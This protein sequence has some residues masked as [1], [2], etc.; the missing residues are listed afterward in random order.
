MRIVELGAAAIDYGKRSDDLRLERMLRPFESGYTGLLESLLAPVNFTDHG[1]AE[2]MGRGIED[3][4]EGIV[5]AERVAVVFDRLPWD[6]WEL[7]RF[8]DQIALT[9]GLKPA[10]IACLAKLFN[11]TSLWA[12]F[13]NGIQELVA[14]DLA[15]L[16]RG[17]DSLKLPA[18]YACPAKERLD[19]ENVSVAFRWTL[20]DPNSIAF[21]YQR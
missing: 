10:G 5:S 8:S 14:T 15:S 12:L 7:R 2:R 19:L 1:E 11:E 17:E 20:P 3:W 4:P 21:L 6:V 9:E 18:I 16:W 13:E